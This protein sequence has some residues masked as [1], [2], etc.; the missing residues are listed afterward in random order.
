MGK[1]IDLFYFKDENQSEVIHLMEE[2]GIPFVAVSEKIPNNEFAGV[3]MIHYALE[4]LIEHN[5]NR[6]IY[7]GYF[8]FALMDNNPKKNWRY[9]KDFIEAYANAAK[10]Y[11]DDVEVLGVLPNYAV[12]DDILSKYDYEVVQ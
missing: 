9:C 3:Y 1:K 10:K 4:Y 7:M 6:S 8:E 2:L 12:V 5:M 11:I